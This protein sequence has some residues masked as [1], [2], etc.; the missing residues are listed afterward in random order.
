MERDKLIIGKRTGKNTIILFYCKAKV[1]VFSC[2]FITK[3]AN[4]I[5]LYITVERSGCY[6]TS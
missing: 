4:F 1:R 2:A 6:P 3:Y 5:L